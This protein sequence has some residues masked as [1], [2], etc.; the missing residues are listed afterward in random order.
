[1]KEGRKEVKERRR[2]KEGMKTFSDVVHLQCVPGRNE[3]RKENDGRMEGKDG[4]ME[5]DKNNGRME[6]MEGR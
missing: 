2:W 1:V 3:G 4:R 5:G 6:R